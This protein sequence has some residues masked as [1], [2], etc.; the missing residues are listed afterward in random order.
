[1]LFT[2]IQFTKQLYVSEFRIQISQN[3]NYN[4]TTMSL[5]N[6]EKDN[7]EL[8]IYIKSTCCRQSLFFHGWL[9]GAL[10]HTYTVV[11]LTYESTAKM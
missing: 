7:N 9:A 11:Q 1:M 4:E 6:D 5:W 3:E 2:I 10:K 8:E